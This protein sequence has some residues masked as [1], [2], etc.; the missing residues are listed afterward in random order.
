MGIAPLNPSHE[1]AFRTGLAAPDVGWVEPKAIPINAIP[2][3]MGIAML[4]PSYE[5]QPRVER[6]PASVSP[7]AIARVNGST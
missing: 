4:N 7:L 2:T 6:G 5:L 1:L 3:T